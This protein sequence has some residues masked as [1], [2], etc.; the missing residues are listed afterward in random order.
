MK[1]YEDGLC[2]LLISVS[3]LDFPLRTSGMFLDFGDTKSLRFFFEIYFNWFT[4]SKRF[5]IW[6]PLLNCIL[7]YSFGLILGFYTLFLFLI[8][9][10]ILIIK[11]NCI[12][13]TNLNY[14]KWNN[15]VINIILKLS[16]YENKEYNMFYSFNIS[17]FVDFIN[18]FKPKF[19][20]F[21]TSRLSMITF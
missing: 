7:N 20:Y 15:L 13:I 21:Q 1:T 5:H 12:F 17:Y 11:I 9:I 4:S 14:L 8:I 16:E 10:E 3:G 18:I 2:S 19:A 6:F